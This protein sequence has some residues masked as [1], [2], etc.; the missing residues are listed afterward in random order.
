MLMIKINMFAVVMYGFVRNF[1]YK[2]SMKSLWRILRPVMNMFGEPSCVPHTSTMVST[3]LKIAFLTLRSID[4]V[5]VVSS[6]KMTSGKE[7]RITMSS[8]NTLFKIQIVRHCQND[9]TTLYQIAMFVTGNS[10]VNVNHEREREREAPKESEFFFLFLMTLA[11]VN[12]H[13]IHTYYIF[14]WKF[15]QLSYGI[16][17]NVL[18]FIHFGSE[19][20]YEDMLVKIF[21][22]ANFTS[23]Y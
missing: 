11:F 6:T 19:M 22:F 2:Q 20:N 17:R 10:L 16:K 9:I 12:V 14:Y 3:D 7:D 15:S 4:D 21:I 1:K 23:K 18:S 13:E 5:I 8:E